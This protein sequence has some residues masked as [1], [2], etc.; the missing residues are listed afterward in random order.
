MTGIQTQFLN[1]INILWSAH[2]PLTNA[3]QVV[4]DKLYRGVTEIAKL[5]KVHGKMDDPG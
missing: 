4:N 2:T 5:V 3:A 1:L